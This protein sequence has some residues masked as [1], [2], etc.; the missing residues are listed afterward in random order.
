VIQGN[1]VDSIKKIAPS[2]VYVPGSNKP[3]LLSIFDSL[4]PVV[5][6][7]IIEDEKFVAIPG[8]TDIKR[9]FKYWSMAEITAFSKNGGVDA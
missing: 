2:R 7:D 9:F 1:I 5:D 8:T 3:H 6:L 4:K